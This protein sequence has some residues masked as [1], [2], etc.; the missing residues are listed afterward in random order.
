VAQSFR[1]IQASATVSSREV[2]DVTR[3]DLFDFL[4][5]R[6]EPWWGRLDEISF[7]DHLYDLDSLPSTDSR[8]ATAR[9]DIGRHRI[10]NY[11]W[12]DDWVVADTRF[13]LADGPDQVLLDF[14]TYMA[15]PVVV[16]DAE[17]ATTLVTHLNRLLSPDG[18]ELR[19]TGFISGRPVYSATRIPGGPGEP[20]AGRRRARI[21]PG[22]SHHCHPDP[23]RGRWLLPPDP[24]GQL[25]RGQQRGGPDG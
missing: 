19:V 12:D 18:W 3:R 11:D 1:E 10:G 5:D 13:Q 22:T 24:G 9:E 17:K 6:P 16:P 2:S 23:P 14:L 15:H 20:A 7:L 4:R 25:D 8:H 21:C